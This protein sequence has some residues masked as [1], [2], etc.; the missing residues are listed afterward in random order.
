MNRGSWKLEE[1][2]DRWGKACVR[3]GGWEEAWC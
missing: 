2:W 3:V 1:E